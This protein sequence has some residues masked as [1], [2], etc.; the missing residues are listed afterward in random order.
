[1]LFIHL[2][3]DGHLNCFSFYMAMNSCV[4]ILGEHVFSCLGSI[5][6]SGISGSYGNSVF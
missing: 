4:Q 3:V 5:P 2:L 1:M 6:R